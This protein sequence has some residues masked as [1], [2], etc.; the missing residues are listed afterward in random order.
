MKT[1]KKL[2]FIYNQKAGK[3][4]I[5]SSLAEVLDVFTKSGYEVTV[6]PTQAVLDAENVARERSGDYDMVVCAG[7]DGT[8]GETATGVYLSGSEVPIGYIP[9]GSTNDYA[10]SISLPKPPVEAAETIMNGI[11]HSFDLGQFND[12]YFIYVAAF[13]W[14]TDV[15]YA[16]DQNLK[17]M[18]G[19]AAYLLE[20]G[21]RLFKMPEYELTIRANGKEFTEKIVYGM[22]S[23]SR[24]I[25]GM[26]DFAWKE[27][28]M[29]D[30]LFEVTLAKK[31]RT[32]IELGETF[33]SLVSTEPSERVIRLKCSEIEVVSTEPFK[34]SIDGEEAEACSHVV[35]K[36]LHQA[37]R[38]M[39]NDNK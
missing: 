2:L 11:E 22:I 29:D 31:P 24:S 33:T 38:L 8:L 19:H 9:C 23:N 34:W 39:V 10:A 14:F 7:G 3:S 28:D 30:G 25:G 15:S 17:N 6:H 32:M 37:L 21:K 13:G 4:S 27:V 18:F 35:A 12:R 1:N 20:A 16:T 5:G 36:N 26:K